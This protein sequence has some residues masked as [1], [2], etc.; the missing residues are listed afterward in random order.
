[1]DKNYTKTYRTTIDDILNLAEPYTFVI[2][3]L[4]IVGN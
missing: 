2:I 1:M 3:I 4:N